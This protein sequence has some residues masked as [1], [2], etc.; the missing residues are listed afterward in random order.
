MI[1]IQKVDYDIDNTIIEKKRLKKFVFRRSL[2]AVFGLNYK[3][4]L[5]M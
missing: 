4:Q 5:T 2:S 3:L 1:F